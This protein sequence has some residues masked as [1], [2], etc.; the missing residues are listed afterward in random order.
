MGGMLGK[1]CDEDKKKS[2][3]TPEETPKEI[4]EEISDHSNLK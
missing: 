4:S 3:E 2:E 1:S